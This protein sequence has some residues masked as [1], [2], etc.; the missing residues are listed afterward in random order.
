MSN[1]HDEKF[2]LIELSPRAPAESGNTEEQISAWSSLV[3]V[4]IGTWRSIRPNPEAVATE[5]QNRMSHATVENDLKRRQIEGLRVDSEAQENRNSLFH[6]DRKI[7]ELELQE[8]A[9]DVQLK[10]E[11]LLR[12]QQERLIEAHTAARLLGMEIST[13]QTADG[14]VIFVEQSRPRVIE[15]ELQ[16]LESAPV[17]EDRTG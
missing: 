1:P 13:F 7:R 15:D 10:K 6:I 9:V 16:V 12:E 3:N 4:V 2:T 17:K 5:L 11:R 14:P 8:K